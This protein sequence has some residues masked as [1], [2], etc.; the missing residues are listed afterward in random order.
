MN[1]RIAIENEIKQL[2]IRLPNGM[3]NKP[4]AAMFRLPVDRISD[5]RMDGAETLGLSLETEG[6]GE[7]FLKGVPINPGDF[8]L[9][10]KFNTLEGEPASE[11]KIPV[12]FN[13]D[14]RD[15]WNKVA[16]D[17][18]VI[19]YKPDSESMCVKVEESKDGRPRK[20]MVA[21][22]QRGRS[23]AREGSPRDDHFKLFHCKESDWYIMAVADGAGSAKYSR[24]GSEVAC[25]AV[26]EHCRNKLSHNPEFENA[27]R[28]YAADRENKEKRTALTG[29]VIDV[30]YNGA[31]KAF[32]A[33]REV[34][35][36]S[37]DSVLKDFATTLMFAV[38]KKFD[39]QWFIASFWV[40]DG[41]IC[42]YDEKTKTAKLLGTPD[43]GEYSGQTR[44]ITM[45][46]IFHERDFASR[47]LR[48]A[49]VPDFTALFLMSDG[50][51]D[52]M[53]ETDRNLNT[54]ERWEEFYSRLKSGF[55]EDNI[56]G[57]DFSADN[58]KVKDQLLDWLDFWSPGNHDDRTI[59]ILF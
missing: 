43:E 3:V 33:V 21:A 7:Y 46:E 47:R 24:K 49:V 11:I 42:L 36:K 27:V 4:Y 9:T 35:E 29:H 31:R 45:P 26:V 48:M 59:A 53:F 2:G 6:N 52:P 56:A 30:V 58:G 22:S 41:A 1:E 10:L 51:S 38:C 23:H 14:P 18:N 28:E 8:T 13:P 32:E 34:A 12:A 17:R 57:V 50:V 16:T 5:V 19:F 39:D 40:G 44:F 20:D 15:L 55:P 25:E 37:E 54:F